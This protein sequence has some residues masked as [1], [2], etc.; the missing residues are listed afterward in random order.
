M[1]DLNAW[2]IMNISNEETM[3]L[4]DRVF[5]KIYGADAD[6]PENYSVYQNGVAAFSVGKVGL[7]EMYEDLADINAEHPLPEWACLKRLPKPKVFV[8][9][10]AHYSIHKSL[11]ILGLGEQAVEKVIVD[12]DS[13][14]DISALR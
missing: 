10:T 3:N 9:A 13:R 6:K 2:E 12:L 5:K 1:V 8:S 14:V 7:M 11:S 4:Y